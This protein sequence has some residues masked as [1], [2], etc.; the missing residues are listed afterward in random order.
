MSNGDELRIGRH[1]KAFDADCHSLGLR[2]Y[3]M[4]DRRGSNSRP[5]RIGLTFNVQNGG[6]IRD[7]LRDDCHD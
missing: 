7:E 2:R 5:E 6:G 1:S 4:A 3:Q